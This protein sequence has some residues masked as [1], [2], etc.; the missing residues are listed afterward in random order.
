LQYP[1]PPLPSGAR[2]A[3]AVEDINAAISE[4]RN[5]GVAVE[6]IGE[7]DE[8]YMAGFKDPFDNRLAL[9]QRKD[10]TWG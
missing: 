8:C 3:L 4:L 7:T 6:D 2:I 9:H 5:K 1:D 10:G